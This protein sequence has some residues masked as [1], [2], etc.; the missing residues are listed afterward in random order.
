MHLK[1]LKFFSEVFSDHIGTK[2]LRKNHPQHSFGTGG[3]HASEF[4]LLV[5]STG[6]KKFLKNFYI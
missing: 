4:F 1:K 5:K 3:V 6:Q 2:G